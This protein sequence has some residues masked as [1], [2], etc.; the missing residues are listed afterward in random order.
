MSPQSF[1]SMHRIALALTAAAGAC[2]AI[3]GMHGQYS[4]IWLGLAATLGG[5]ATSLAALAPSTSAARNVQAVASLKDGA[6]RV[7]AVHAARKVVP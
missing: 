4:A 3:G 2:T 1:T 5:T 7:E 6:E